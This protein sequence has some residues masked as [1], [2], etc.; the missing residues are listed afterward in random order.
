MANMIRWQG[1]VALV[2]GASCG[3][4]AAIAES[5]VRYGMQVVGCARNIAE[6]QNL[7]SRLKGEKGSL[8][9]IQCDLTK[10]DE[11]LAMFEEI[12]KNFKGVDVCINNAGLSHCAPLLSG[13]TSQWRQMLDVNVLGPTI[14]TREAVKSMRS[15]NVDDGHIVHIGSIVGHSVPANY[16]DG[17]FYSMSKF[18]VRALTEGHRNELRELGSH[19]RVSSISPGLVETQFAIR[20]RGEERGKQL[21]SSF[22]PLQ[23]NDI[24]DGVIYVLSAPAHVQV[25]DIIIRPNESKS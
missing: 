3:I 16:T 5:L 12:S 20:M 9:A 19:I 22:T 25:H 17:H 10:E 8:H 7:A 4:G 15:R 18:A 11:I 21:Y 2:T 23:A 6:I 14:C 13:D 1:R 24:V